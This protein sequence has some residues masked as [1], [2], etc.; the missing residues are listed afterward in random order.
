MEL[1]WYVLIV[2]EGIKGTEVSGIAD[3]HFVLIP[4]LLRI[5]QS[6]SPSQFLMTAILEY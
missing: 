3:K 4:T 2:L 1:W 5:R 6:K